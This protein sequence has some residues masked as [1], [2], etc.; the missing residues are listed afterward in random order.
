MY[1]HIF[2]H[3]G[4][5]KSSKHT[6]LYN[7]QPSHHVRQANSNVESVVTVSLVHGNVIETEIAL[8]DQMK[9]IVVSS[10]IL[11]SI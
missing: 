10:H 5:L 9:K 11:C 2:M 8:M 4:S 6:F 7:L 1:V 3:N